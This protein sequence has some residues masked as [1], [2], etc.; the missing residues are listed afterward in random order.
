MQGKCRA[1]VRRGAIG[2]HRGGKPG[3]IG[4]ETIAQHMQES[5][6]AVGAEGA[7]AIEYFSCIGDARCLALAGKQSGAQ[8]CQAVGRNRLVTAH[9]VQ[10]HP[11]AVGDGVQQVSEERAAVHRSDR[12]R[13]A[14]GRVRRGMRVRQ[15]IWRVVLD[16]PIKSPKMDR[17]I[18][19]GGSHVTSTSAPASANK[20]LTGW[21][22]QR[23]PVTARR[24][25]QRQPATWSAAVLIASMFAR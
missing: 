13:G 25:R 23:V 3:V 24:Q 2:I 18:L 20:F 7:P 14:C 9:E 15:R 11:A 1:I 22:E 17:V 19:A 12:R 4:A 6:P 5:Q 10:H 8:T 16:I 21:G